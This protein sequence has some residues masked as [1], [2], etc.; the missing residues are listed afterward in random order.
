M[1][2]SIFYFSPYLGKISNLTNMFQ[3]GW[4]HQPAQLHRK[5]VDG[6]Y[7]LF[8]TLVRPLNKRSAHEICPDGN[9]NDTSFSSKRHQKQL[10]IIQLNSKLKWTLIQCCFKFE[11]LPSMHGQ[12]D[13]EIAL[14]LFFIWQFKISVSFH[15]G[16]EKE[17]GKTAVS[18]SHIV[19]FF[20]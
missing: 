16:L 3:R 15:G 10:Y 6:L 4:N 1:V 19:V 9:I 12:F 14:L 11:W 18:S 2:S 5:N 13:L 17:S 7:I 20:V 8:T